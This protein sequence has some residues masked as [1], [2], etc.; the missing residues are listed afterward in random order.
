MVSP[1]QMCPQPLRPY[2]TTSVRAHRLVTSLSTPVFRAEHGLTQFQCRVPAE[3]S[4]GRTW[5]A[6]PPLQSIHCISLRG[7]EIAPRDLAGPGS[8][9]CNATSGAGPRR[10]QCPSWLPRSN[11]ERTG[12]L[13]TA[14]GAQRGP[15]S[16]WGV[17][18][19]PETLH[20]D[21]PAPSAGSSCLTGSQHWGKCTR[22][23]KC[24]LVWGERGTQA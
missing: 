21:S 23:Q 3:P 10:E 16:L 5:P 14:Q 2:V 24:R 17:P 1:I 9:H 13:P 18:E 11:Q 20:T 22:Q 8:L 6:K 4:G 7:S 19:H 15:P 12:Y